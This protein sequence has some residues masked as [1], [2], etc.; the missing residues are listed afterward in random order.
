M[1][2]E[3]LTSSLNKL[4]VCKSQWKYVAGFKVRFPVWVAV[5]SRKGKI[6]PVYHMKIYIWGVEVQ[7][8]SFLATPLTR[9]ERSSSRTSRGASGKETLFP[10]KLL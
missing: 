7:L 2:S 1:R 6:V 10:C 4:P 9:G 5:C 3:F 8:H